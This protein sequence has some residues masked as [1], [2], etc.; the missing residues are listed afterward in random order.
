MGCTAV[1]FAMSQDLQFYQN[2]VSYFG[3]LAPPVISK[4]SQSIVFKLTCL[5]F[6]YIYDA[7]T[8]FSMDEFLPS[9]WFSQNFIKLLCYLNPSVCNF[10]DAMFSDIDPSSNDKL[11]EKVFFGHFPS[12]S[13]LKA[14][15]HFAQ[16]S[17]SNV[18]Q[19]YDYGSV[20]NYKIYGQFDPPE[21][22]LNQ[23]SGIPIGMFVG[24]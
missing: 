19:R 7:L 24:Y 3:A 22:K 2:K 1:L 5:V 16:I 9:T 17:R 15:N 20:V 10:V 12:G 8:F 21:I 14:I 23:I 11:A 4:Y 18:F 6:D 13:S